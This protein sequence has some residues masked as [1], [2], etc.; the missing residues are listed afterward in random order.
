M[1]W[2]GQNKLNLL[3]CLSLVAVVCLL[4]PGISKGQYNNGNTQVKTAPSEVQTEEELRE[5]IANN[6]LLYQRSIGGW[7]KHINNVKI[8]Y[9]RRLSP[10]EIAAVKDDAFRNDATID[11]GSTVKEIRFLA[12]EYH[13]TGNKAFLHAVEKGLDYLLK[14]Q[15][16]NGGW[17]QFYPDLSLYRH[18][19]TYNDHAMVN[20]L[21]LLYDVNIRSNDLEH[22]DGTYIS[23]SGKA[24]KRGIDCIL[25]TQIKVN[26]QLTA[27]CAQ[28]DEKTLKPARAR[29]FELASLCSMES[30]GVLY[31]LMRQEKPSKAVC[32]A[33]TAGVEWLDKVKINGYKYIDGEDPKHDSG[34]DR[35][36]VASENSVVWARFYEIASFEPFVCGRD[37][38]MKRNLTD[39]E[40]ERR[41]GYA[42]YGTWPSKLLEEDY[43]AWAKLHSQKNMHHGS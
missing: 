25:K 42:W 34:R 15:Y 6:M 35:L 9:S 21:N 32:K 13:L 29:A 24:I 33:V 4:Y 38:I 37:G 43:P 10:G 23:K 26:G 5:V 41:I 16:A 20:V 1:G 30:V 39:I 17:P 2:P 18:Q 28:H 31:F 11:N 36:L 14:A 12:H 22:V 3:K 27:W 8:D 19:I 7:P 40:H